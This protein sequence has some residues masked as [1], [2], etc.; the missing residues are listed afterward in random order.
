MQGVAWSFS[1]N[2]VLSCAKGEKPN[3]TRSNK[4]QENRA[5][6]WRDRISI[7]PDVCEGKARIKG[8]RVM[9]SVILDNLAHGESYEEIMSG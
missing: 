6:D 8:T 7:D 1:T 5:M 3:L 2:V 4:I 9:V